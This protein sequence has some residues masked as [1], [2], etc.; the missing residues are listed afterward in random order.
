MKA[1]EINLPK[2]KYQT[3]HHLYGDSYTYDSWI[4]LV[5]DTLKIAEE[6]AKK[7]LMS[8]LI[9]LTMKI[10]DEML[11]SVVTHET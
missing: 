1:Q 5:D 10:S 7:R 6:E 3:A 8:D 9:E 11:D 4:K 2:E